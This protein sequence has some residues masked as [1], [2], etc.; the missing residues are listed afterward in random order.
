MTVLP[1]TASR[2]CGSVLQSWGMPTSTLHTD[3]A[4]ALSSGTPDLAD[5][6]RVSGI[7]RSVGLLRR[8]RPPV[9]PLAFSR[10]GS[11]GQAAWEFPS[12]NTRDVTVT[13]S[14]L[15]YAGRIRDNTDR[16]QSRSAPR[17]PFWVR[18]VN[19]LHRFIV[20][21]LQTQVPLVS[22]DHR[23]GRSATVWLAA[24]EL[25][26]AGFRPPGLPRR[27]ACRVVLAPLSEYSS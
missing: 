23:T 16:F 25:L 24:A 19:H 8:L 1:S 20:T 21:T 10:P 26:S 3:K 13:R 11:P 14:C 27:A 7:T 12:S 2:P 18:C 9:R 17:L 22:I 6:H 5:L 4:G 15:L